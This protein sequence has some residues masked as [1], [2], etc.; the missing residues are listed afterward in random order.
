MNFISHFYLDREIKDGLFFIGL[1]APDLLPIYNRS[2]RLRLSV[3]PPLPPDATPTMQSFHAGVLRHFQGDQVFHDSPLFK[4]ETARIGGYLREVLRP[5][6]LKRSFFLAHI[7]FELALDKHLIGADET[8][9]P[10]FYAY[11]EQCPID[12]MQALCE[13]AARTP[14]PGFGTFIERFIRRRYLARYTDWQ[15]I[16]HVLRSVL[17]GV[18]LRDLD[19]LHTPR[20]LRM[21]EQYERELATHCHASLTTIA[22]ALPPR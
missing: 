13:W 17:E 19:Y 12:E 9:I 22:Q 6:E 7:L 1:S 14:L 20:F 15:H 2:I 11:W 21:A 5:E 3:L 18:G 10:E 8:L 4:T 16:I